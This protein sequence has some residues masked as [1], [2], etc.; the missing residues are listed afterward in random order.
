MIFDFERCF[1]EPT[2][3]LFT[4]P[5]K[6]LHETKKQAKQWLEENKIEGSLEEY[7]R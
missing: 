4:G 1:F 7:M 2:S 5:F 3:W 6:G